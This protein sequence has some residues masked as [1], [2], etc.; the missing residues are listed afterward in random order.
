MEKSLKISKQESTV[1]K[2]CHVCGT[3]NE[4]HKEASRCSGCKK[5]F[6]PSNYFSKVHDSEDAGKTKSYEDWIY[7]TVD[8]LDQ[9]DVIKGL[10]V[11]W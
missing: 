8:E 4:G 6:M 7:S 2:K 1:I 3:I 9:R 11:I 5:P 10:T